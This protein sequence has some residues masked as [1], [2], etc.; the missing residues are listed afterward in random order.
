[1]FANVVVA[2]PDLEI[3]R[4]Y[5]PGG[6]LGK[7]YSPAALVVAVLVSFVAVFISP[8]VA[9]GT[10]APALSLMVPR[11]TAEFDVCAPAAIPSESTPGIK[12]AAKRKRTKSFIIPPALAG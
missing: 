11:M 8:T 4:V 1:M 6:T 3:F 2:K 7:T 12:T 5:V 10:T 9:S